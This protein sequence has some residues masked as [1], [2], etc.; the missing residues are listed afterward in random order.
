MS[1]GAAHGR[2]PRFSPDELH[3][4]RSAVTR[5]LTEAELDAALV[6]GANRTGSAIQWLTEWPVTREASLVLSPD[7]DDAMWVEFYNHLPNARRMATGTTVSWDGHDTTVPAAAELSRRGARR[8]GVI[9]PLGWRQHA[10]L[11]ASFEIVSLDGAYV[12]E[13]LIKSDEELEWM[14]HAAR[15]SDGAI[16]AIRDAVSPGMT[17]AEIGAVCESSYL[18]TGAT[19][20]IHYLGLTSMDAPNQCVPS[21]WPTDR[22][23]EIGDVLTCEISASWWGYAGQ[24][25]RT[26]AIGADPSPLYRDLHDVADAAFDAICGV[27]RPGAS[28]EQV[29]EAAA[30]IEDAGYTIYDDLVHGYG[31]G[32]FP[33]ILG[34]SSRA[35]A[36]LPDMTF[37]EG[38][39]VV[40]QPNVITTDERAGVQTGGLVAITCDGVE[41]LQRAPRG[42]WRTSG[43]V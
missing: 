25:L 4:R 7:L 11:A 26:I 41:Q 16:E 2:Y 35:N 37:E 36:P 24:V 12:R 21:Q 5:M 14:R 17:E 15:L 40:V 30:V 28:P 29:I 43:G 10:V 33:P 27:L 31:G 8:V 3:R 9:G 13:R 19:N 38:M 23:V 6:F 22:V 18:H 42:L 34:S 32:Y 1:D 39:T 20:H